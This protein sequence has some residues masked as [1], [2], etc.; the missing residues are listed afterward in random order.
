MYLH[1]INQSVHEQ[2]A[3]AERWERQGKFKNQF[4]CL[5]EEAEMRENVLKNTMHLVH[6]YGYQGETQLGEQVEMLSVHIARTE[7]PGSTWGGRR[8]FDFLR[9]ER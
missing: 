2:Q 3:V 5:R 4:L 6:L 1:L 9:E 7:G 8:L